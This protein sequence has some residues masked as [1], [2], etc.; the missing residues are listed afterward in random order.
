M[1]RFG[2]GHGSLAESVVSPST[3]H[4]TVLGQRRGYGIDR[5]A[6]ES[7]YLER[8]AA[9]HP[10]RVANGSSGEKRRAM[11]ISS[12]VNEA[13]RVLRHPVRRAEYLVKLGGIDLDSSDPQTGAPKMPQTFLIEMI[14]RRETLDAAKAQG[15][16][17][18]DDVRETVESELDDVLDDAV[19]SLEA[20]DI[21]AAAQRLVTRRYL[22]RLLDE[23]ERES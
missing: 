2:T 20:G 6:L 21:P 17:A 12:A 8:A 16:A 9:A 14:E 4:F 11:E 13:Y 7:A 22:Q 15:P 5:D 10:D 18:L 23:V 1:R 19:E 3:D